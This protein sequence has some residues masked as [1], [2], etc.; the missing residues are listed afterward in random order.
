MYRY[1][2]CDRS[3]ILLEVTL[4]ARFYPVRRADE[5]SVFLYWVDLI[6]LDPLARI[7]LANSQS[8][9]HPLKDRE[10]FCHKYQE[11][12]HHQTSGEIDQ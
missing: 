8:S 11:P 2:D 12:I 6:P 9:V 3:L 10:Q 7:A 1:H 4:R 5:F